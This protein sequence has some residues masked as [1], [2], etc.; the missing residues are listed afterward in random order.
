MAY[1][2]SSSQVAIIGGSFAPLGG[3][4]F[5]EACAVGVPVIVG[6]HTRNFEQAVQDALA[7]QAIVQVPGAAAAL[8]EATRLLHETNERT[9]LAEAGLHWM[10]KHRGSVQRVL[11]G[12]NKILDRQN[13]QAKK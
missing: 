12:L 5:I 2:Y 4:N 11:T 7:E 6:P 10:H 8:K 9:R 13:R 3:Q 1:Y